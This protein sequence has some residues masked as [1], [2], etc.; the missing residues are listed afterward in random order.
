MT[1]AVADYRPAQEA[2]Q[3]LKR[4][5]A[6][7]RTRRSS[8]SQNPDLLAELGKQRGAQA[9]PLLVGFA[10][11]TEDVIGNAEKKLATEAVRSGRRERRQRAGLGLRGRHQP[12]HARRHQRGDRG[13]GRDQGR[14]RAPDP[15]SRGRDAGR[16][17]PARAGQADGIAEAAG[18]HEA[19]HALVLTARVRGAR[20]AIAQPSTRMPG[21]G[22]FAHSSRISPAIFACSPASAGAATT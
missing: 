20:A 2:K 21:A 10:A 16:G 12:G 4:G 9:T 7:R 8:W 3:K 22:N 1:A 11:E 14:G 17:G 5:A 6:R 13:P 19:A 18:A 15:R